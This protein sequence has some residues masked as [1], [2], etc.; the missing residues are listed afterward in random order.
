M[1]P[2]LIVSYEVSIPQWNFTCDLTSVPIRDYNKGAVVTT[3]N[4]LCLLML[5][6]MVG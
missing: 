2:F 6:G 5:V 4:L 1:T 3:E